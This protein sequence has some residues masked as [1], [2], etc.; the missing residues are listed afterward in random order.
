MHPIQ[1]AKANQYV[2]LIV[3]FLFLI[4]G[5]LFA[6]FW[7]YSRKSRVRFTDYTKK[8]GDEVRRFNWQGASYK[9]GECK[10]FRAMPEEKD[11]VFKEDDTCRSEERR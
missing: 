4:F 9:N 10:I 6:V 5:A 11:N 8:E 3:V 2:T 1:T 7:Y